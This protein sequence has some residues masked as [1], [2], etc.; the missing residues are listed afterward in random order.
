[1]LRFRL[2]GNRLVTIPPHHLIATGPHSVKAADLVAGDRIKRPY[3]NATPTT[4]PA[5]ED[6]ERGS[7]AWSSAYTLVDTWGRT[8][9][10]D[11]MQAAGWPLRK[12][13]L[14]LDWEHA[15]EFVTAIAIAMGTP[16]RPKP[17]LPIRWTPMTQ[18]QTDILLRHWPRLK[19]RGIEAPVSYPM[20][21]GARGTRRTEE[22]T[23]IYVLER[24]EAPDGTY[25]PGPLTTFGPG[26]TPHE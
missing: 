25:D 13:P 17:H 2:T 18:M 11:V 6:R 22:Y 19:I 7:V 5:G 20:L 8:I 1:M 14:P 9:L 3:P 15:A 10:S 23:D 26:D 21:P 4:V 12:P 24:T 16:H